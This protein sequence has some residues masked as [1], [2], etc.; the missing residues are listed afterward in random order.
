V[1][2]VT[3]SVADIPGDVAKAL[4]IRVIPLYIQFGLETFR[5][6]VDMLEEEFYR[7]LESVR[8]LPKTS[9]PSPNDF[10]QVYRALLNMK[11]EIVS[12]HPTAQLSGTYNTAMLAREMLGN[13]EEIEVVDCRTG[14]AGQGLIALEAA[15]CALQGLGRSQIA[16]AVRSMAT[17]VRMYVALETLEYMAR[18]GRVGKAKVFMASLLRIKPIITLLNGEVEPVDKVRGSSKIVPRLVDLCADLVRSARARAAITHAKAF[19]Q[20]RRLKAEMEARLGV[21]DI[22][23]SSM[24][25]AVAANAG[26]GALAVAIYEPDQPGD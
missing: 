10:L 25:P 18:N 2:I 16:E 6:R 19:E 4:G 5:D 23:V 1:A 7:K 9:Q 24:C 8:E 12:V 22:M 26:P 3:D 20:A 11:R 14:S 13:P 17:K 15:K 21:A